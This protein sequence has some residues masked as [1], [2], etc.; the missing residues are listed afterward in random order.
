MAKFCKGG[1]Q[2]NGLLAVEEKG[3]YFG[4]CGGSHD[5]AENVTCRVDWTV[6]G[7]PLEGCLLRVDWRIAEE[8]V[9]TGSAGRVG[10]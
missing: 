7:R 5:I 2:W 9:A 6:E 8:V 1:A 3:S 4:L 10:C